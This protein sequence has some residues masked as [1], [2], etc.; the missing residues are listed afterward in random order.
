MRVFA[1]RH[2]RPAIVLVTIV[3]P[4]VAVP[5]TV[6]DP[7]RGR[8]SNATTNVTIES[9]TTMELVTA[10]RPKVLSTPK[11]SDGLRQLSNLPVAGPALDLASPF[12]WIGWRSGSVGWSGP[13]TLHLAERGPPLPSGD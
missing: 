10:D 4:W 3:L 13:L 6:D 11:R 12:V 1:A 2:A 7:N 9:A 8:P 5:S